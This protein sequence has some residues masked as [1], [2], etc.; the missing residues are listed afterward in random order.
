MPAT[1][2][3][4]LGLSQVIVGAFGE[5]C[6]CQQLGQ[7]VPRPGY[8]GEG[9][10]GRLRGLADAQ[11]RV[12]VGGLGAAGAHVAAECACAE[13]SGSMIALGEQEPTLLAFV[14]GQV[15]CSVQRFKLMVARLRIR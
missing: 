6:P 10:G 14:A 1:E 9:V 4:P 5:A 2:T 7:A 13:W 15:T 12:L 11:E 8:V 3:T